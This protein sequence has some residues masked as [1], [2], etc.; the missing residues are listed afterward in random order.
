M[1]VR[2]FD[3][4]I[5]L[6]GREGERRIDGAKQEKSVAKVYRALTQAIV[7]KLAS[8]PRLRSFPLVVKLAVKSNRIS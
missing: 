1:P 8:N 5:C 2:V 6:E 4:V 7:E 3:E